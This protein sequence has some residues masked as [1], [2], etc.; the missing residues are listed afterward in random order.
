MRVAEHLGHERFECDERPQRGVREAIARCTG[1]EDLLDQRHLHDRLV[2]AGD[3]D[4][5]RLGLM[6]DRVDRSGEFV[7][8]IGERGDEI[9]EHDRR[10]SDATELDLIRV[11]RNDTEREAPQRR[12]PHGSTRLEMAVVVTG[13]ETVEEACRGAGERGSQT[14]EQLLAI[15]PHLAHVLVDRGS[16]LSE[17]AG[18]RIDGECG[19]VTEQVAD[20][21]REQERE[22]RMHL[23]YGDDVQSG[24]EPD[25]ALGGHDHGRRLVGAVDRDL[26]G[27]VIGSRTGQARGTDEDHRLGREIDVLLVLGAIAGDRLV[28]ELAQLDAH[29]FG[30]DAIGTVAD[31]GP[32]AAR[33]RDGRRSHADLLAKCERAIERVGHRSQ[34]FEQ[35]DALGGVGTDHVGDR[36][37]EQEAGGDLRVERLRGGHAHLDVATIGR[38]EHAVGAVGE[39]AVATIDDRHHVG[40]PGPHEVDRS[41]GVGRGTRLTHRDHEGVVHRFGEVE[42]AQF[43]GQHRL[44]RERRIGGEGAQRFDQRRCG[45]G[46]S[47]LTDGEHSCDRTVDESGP[48]VGRQ[49]R[50]VESHHGAVGAVEQLAPKCLAERGRCLSDLLE[51]EVRRITAID[52]TGRDLSDGDVIGR[53][54]D[55]RAVVGPTLESLERT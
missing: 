18:L 26:L 41:V 40:A 4:G 1:G 14:T 44:H 46:S 31:D 48:N 17:R 28:T 30:G 25:L 39:I 15:A 21:R 53:D 11:E 32:V 3:A 2:G 33:R 50:V 42:T 45:D 19:F 24:A 23:G 10:R 9:L 38:V 20:H 37:S 36:S 52:V 55:R 13:T 8:G 7:D 49:H 43:G 27:D 12:Q 47:A 34:R 51:Q 35:C 54:R 16:G 5:H 29:L 6:L 22:A